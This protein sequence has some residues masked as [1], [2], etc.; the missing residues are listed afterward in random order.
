MCK[1]TPVILYG[2]AFPEVTHDIKVFVWGCRWVQ[3]SVLERL[4]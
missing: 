3:D 4:C 1:V 2:D